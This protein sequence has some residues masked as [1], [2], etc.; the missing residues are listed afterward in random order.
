[1]Y[2]RTK[3]IRR[4]ERGFTLIEMLVAVTL[5]SVVMLVC[6]GALLALVAANKKAEALESVVNNLNIAVDGMVRSVREGSDYRCGSSSGGDCTNG[7]TALYY[8]PYGCDPTK[9][10]ADWVYQFAVDSNGVGRIYHYRNDGR[11][12]ISDGTCIPITAPDVDIESLTFY[13]VGS[14]RGDTTQ[15]KVI[16]EIKGKAGGSNLKSNSSFHIQATAVQRIL[17]I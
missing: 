7:G 4:T 6:I 11:C 14:T 13:V 17:D 10:C 16:F 9:G 3:K 5:F 2:L 12:H 8:Q 15:P 1:M